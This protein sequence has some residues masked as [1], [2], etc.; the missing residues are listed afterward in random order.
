MKSGTADLPGAMD[1]DDSC[2]AG[3]DD[4]VYMISEDGKVVVLRGEPERTV[5]AVNDLAES[6][7]AAPAIVEGTLLIRTRVA[8]YGFRNVR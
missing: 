5:E 7:C 1:D 4:K 8:L 6:A 3:R 2:P